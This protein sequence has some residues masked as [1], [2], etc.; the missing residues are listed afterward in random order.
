MTA[1]AFLMAAKTEI[2][3]KI[4]QLP[5]TK[6]RD[7]YTQV[8]Q[9]LH[10]L[11]YLVEIMERYG[12]AIDFDNLFENIENPVGDRDREAISAIASVRDCSERLLKEK[13]NGNKR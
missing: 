7:K 3:D 9:M 13:G 5:Q 11:G 2:D 10:S 6:L 4:A 8:S 1:K 12:D